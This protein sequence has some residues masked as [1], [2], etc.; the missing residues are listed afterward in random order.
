MF[1]FLPKTEFQAGLGPIPQCSV[2]I[3]ICFLL[4]ISAIPSAIPLTRILYGST[5]LVISRW[6]FLQ[7]FTSEFQIMLPLPFGADHWLFLVT[8]IPEGRLVIADCSGARG[9]IQ[10]FSISSTKAFTSALS[11]SLLGFC[12]SRWLKYSVDSLPI[13]FLSCRRYWLLSSEV[14]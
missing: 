11:F 13:V 4:V 3:P 8:A 1:H 5:L 6:F 7:A 10:L 14:G 2:F 9:F 12:R